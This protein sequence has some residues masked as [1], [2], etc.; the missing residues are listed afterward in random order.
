MVCYIDVKLL[1]FF[2]ATNTVHAMPPRLMNS[3]DRFVFKS[4]FQWTNM[5]YI[6]VF[7]D[8]IARSLTGYVT[9]LGRQLNQ[10]TGPTQPIGLPS[11]ERNLLGRACVDHRNPTCYQLSAT[12][13]DALD[14]R[15][16][17]NS[18]SP[19]DVPDQTLSETRSGPVEPM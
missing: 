16:S 6:H 4:S 3:S 8:K 2:Y 1:V 11:A 7:H 14:R 19:L 13:V 5:S 10:L 9:A 18:E 17:S 15:R 12:K